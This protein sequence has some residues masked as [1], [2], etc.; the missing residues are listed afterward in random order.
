MLCVH[1]QAAGVVHM[2]TYVLCTW[3]RACALAAAR[4]CRQLTVL[5]LVKLH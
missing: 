4:A 1:L 3:A 5:N 2:H